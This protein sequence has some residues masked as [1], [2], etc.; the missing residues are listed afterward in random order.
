MGRVAIAI[1]DGDTRLQDVGLG[2]LLEELSHPLQVS[3]AHEVVASHDDDVTGVGQRDRLDVVAAGPQVRLV[4][5]VT[6]AR[7]AES[8]EPLAC[9]QVRVH[10]VD[11]DQSPV[12]D[13]LRAHALHRLLK[14]IDAT[15]EG[16]QDVDR[17]RYFSLR[18]STHASTPHNGRMATGPERPLRV[19]F[20][21]QIFEA[22][23]RGGVSKYFVELI[24]RLPAH[25]IE[26]VVLS[27]ATRNIHLAQSGLVPAASPRSPIVER[28]AWVGWR[29]VGRPRSTPAVGSWPEID[30]MHHT[31]GHPSYLR[32]WNG[33]RVTTV[34][35]MTPEL[36]P[37][38]FKLGNPHFAKR[39]YAEVSDA[40]ITI[41]Q[42]TAEDMLRL[43]GMP[44]LRE[45]TTTIPLG[46]GE[47]FFR[48]GSRPHGLPT[49]YLL[50]VGVRS[51]YKDFSV[52]LAAWARLAAADE[53]LDLVMVGG[54][55]LSDAE[56]RDIRSTGSGS[57]L[58][59]LMPSDDE[60]VEIY[61]GAEALVFPSRYE[62]FGLPTL[63]ALAAG[64][65]VVL[66]DAS[67]SREVGGDA[68]LY[69]PPGDV[70][71]LI[72]R[73]TEAI[74]PSH[75]AVIR[76]A[77]PARAA[78]FSWDRTAALTADVYRRVADSQK[79]PG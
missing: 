23:K 3:R 29:L 65:P 19:G 61:R 17:H 40:V 45:K 20:D 32:S 14:V 42:N 21:D 79:A 41:S 59:H 1:D 24:E 58:H 33:P 36:F 51:G 13:G 28:A 22:Q 68:A 25:G 64:T 6:D 53:T 30:L 11:H 5:H 69:F 12:V 35:D 62:G 60:I 34:Y 46:V 38:L 10:V 57:R 48:P 43:Y 66:A 31:F 15:V 55:A 74:A 52:A 9:R 16:H 8:F 67:C 47:Q 72:A 27:R 75:T 18:D 63:E 54:G 50:F 77:G 73:I 2:M 26:P 4:A 56:R 71:A 78:L 44:G 70:D 7:V 49:R 37:E 39:R 76:S